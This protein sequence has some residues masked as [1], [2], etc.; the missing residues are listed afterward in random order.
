MRIF[1]GGAMKTQDKSTRKCTAAAA[2]SDRVRYN[3]KIHLYYIL[4]RLVIFV[5][6]SK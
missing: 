1:A 4:Y 3:I 2:V 5:L 6:A